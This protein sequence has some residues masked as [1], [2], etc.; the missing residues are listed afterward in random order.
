MI[1]SLIFD[2]ACIVKWVTLIK[3]LPLYNGHFCELPTVAAKY[4]FDCITTT[5][6]Y[7]REKCS[8]SCCLQYQWTH[9]WTVGKSDLSLSSHQAQVTQKIWWIW[10][11]NVSCMIRNTN[12]QN[13]YATNERLPGIN[14]QTY[15]MLY[16]ITMHQRKCTKVRTSQHSN[17][18]R[19][20]I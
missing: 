3:W 13:V 8:V 15:T 17:F 4:R 19:F 12:Y 10:L 9:Y 6:A 5:M 14:I 7:K 2:F 20:Q 16:L 11:F 18:A 1:L